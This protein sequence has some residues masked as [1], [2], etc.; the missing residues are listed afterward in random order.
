[1]IQG[2]YYSYIK[3]SDW[4]CKVYR[5]NNLLGSVF[6]IEN[7]WNVEYVGDTRYLPINSCLKILGYNKKDNED[8]E[9]E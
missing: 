5:N 7:A 6:I 4:L 9:I 1:M 3:L 8:M 2:K